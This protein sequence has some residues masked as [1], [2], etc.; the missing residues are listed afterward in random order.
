MFAKVDLD[1]AEKRLSLLIDQASLSYVL[2]RTPEVITPA[3]LSA[4]RR[5]YFDTEIRPFVQGEFR[6]SFC[7]RPMDEWH[8]GGMISLT[9]FGYLLLKRCESRQD[10]T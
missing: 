3:G 9:K 4:E 1:D 7:L 2:E 10:V 5:K 8:S 6:D